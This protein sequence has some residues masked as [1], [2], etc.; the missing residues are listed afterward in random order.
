MTCNSIHFTFIMF[1]HRYSVEISSEPESC[2]VLK[3]ADEVLDKR[4]IEIFD[5]FNFQRQWLKNLVQKKMKII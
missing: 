4:P 3:I 5:M 2:S 1:I